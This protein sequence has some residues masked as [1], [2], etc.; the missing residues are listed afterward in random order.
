MKV[1]HVCPSHIA[2]GGT[3][4]IHHLVSELDKNNDIDACILYVGTNLVNPQPVVYQKYHCRYVT[5]LPDDY[6]VIIFPEVYANHVIDAPYRNKITVVN[7]QGV[8]VYDWNVPVNQRGLF[9]YN[10][11]TIHVTMS[12]YGMNYLRNLGLN[13][14]KI[15]DCIND[16]YLQPFDKEYER[17]NVVLYNPVQVKLTEFQKTV[18]QKCVDSGIQF[19]PLTG[20]TQEQL[21]D[22]FRH[23]KLYIDFGVFSGRER[24]PREAVMCG[25]CILTSKKGTAGYYRDNAILDKYKIDDVEIAIQMIDYILKNY[26]ECKSDF[27]EYKRLMYQD[28]E[29]YPKQVKELCNAFFNYNSSL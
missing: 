9:L 1:F 27:N 16:D 13:P 17:N 23:S 14:I 19:R 5:K 22:I 24:L 18:M 28:K 25:C 7:W 8:D 2:T 21:I 4:G 12:E 11:K 10:K 6:D 20:Y 15:P 3:E 26:D 29:L